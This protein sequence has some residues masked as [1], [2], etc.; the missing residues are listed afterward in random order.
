[1]AG[2]V[3]P[4]L[5]LCGV[6]LRAQLLFVLAYSCFLCCL[7]Y[8]FPLAFAHWQRLCVPLLMV[9]CAPALCGST[10]IVWGVSGRLPTA[11]APR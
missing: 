8:L 11:L 4:M 10:S 5:D 3:S 6:W 1:M 7:G 2:V 9:P